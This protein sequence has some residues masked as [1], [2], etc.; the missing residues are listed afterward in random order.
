MRK[1][2]TVK[3]KV[4]KKA[5][6]KISRRSGEAKKNVFTY[7]PLNNERLSFHG[8]MRRPEPNEY[9][10][11][12]GVFV[13]R[14]ERRGYDY[15][16]HFTVM[17]AGTPYVDFIKAGCRRWKNFDEAYAHYGKSSHHFQ[18]TRR[19]ALARLRFL[20]AK[21]VNLQEVFESHN[22]TIPALMTEK[23]G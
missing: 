12:R 11:S 18:T 21:V 19:Q 22:E 23:L 16:V 1:K 2:T 4:A 3:K 9:G 7:L 15:K 10:V 6:K 8:Q 5:V 17:S 20:E 13:V 14:D